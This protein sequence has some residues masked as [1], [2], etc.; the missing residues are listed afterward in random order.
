MSMTR[1]EVRW[2]AGCGLLFGLGA[3]LLWAAG[4]LARTDDDRFDVF[5]DTP[6]DDAVAPSDWGWLH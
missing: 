6:A 2:L 3:G 4:W 1:V 5:T